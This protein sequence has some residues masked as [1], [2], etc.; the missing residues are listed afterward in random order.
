[1]REYFASQRSRVRKLTR[2]S[3]ERAIRASGN[4]ELQDGV[5]AESDLMLPIET[6]PLSSV[7][8]SN[9]E[10]APSCSNQD[11]VLPGLGESERHFVDNI[12]SSMCKEET[13]SGQVK[14]MEWI[15]QIENPT[16]LSW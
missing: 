2:L 10:E 12:F 5:P 16:I 7:G 13:F 14:L 3:R 4:K 9:V 8:P 1:M 11:E 6:A 15:L